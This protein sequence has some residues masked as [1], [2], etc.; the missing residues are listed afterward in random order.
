MAHYGR[1]C[2]LIDTGTVWPAP[3]NCSLRR[4][5]TALALSSISP[6][7]TPLSAAPAS[8]V[9]PPLLPEPPPR[10]QRARAEPL[11]GSADALALA[12][13]AASAA[14]R[15]ELTAIVCAQALAVQ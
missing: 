14:E 10:G 15:G 2:A 12:Q 3:Y 13:H 11:V 8:P 9:L 6:V 4:A 5:L 1:G 7:S